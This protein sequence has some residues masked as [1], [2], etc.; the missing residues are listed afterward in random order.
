MVHA[1]ISGSTVSRSGLV[2][3]RTPRTSRSSCAAV[4]VRA[5]STQRCWSSGVATFVSARTC[6][7]DNRPDLNA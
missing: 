4:A 2:A 6:E 5:G 1:A 3:R 7:Y